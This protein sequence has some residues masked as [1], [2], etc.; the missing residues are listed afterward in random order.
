MHQND[1]SGADLR[2]LERAREELVVGS[3]DGVAAL[4]GDHVNVLGQLGADLGGGLAGELAH[5]HV[6][7]RDLPAAVVLA[8]LGGDHEH[9]WVLDGARVRIRGR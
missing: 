2:R 5:G 7:T 1:G 3:M 8:S 9:S 4:E 6:E